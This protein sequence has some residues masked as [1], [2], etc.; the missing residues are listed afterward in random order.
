LTI[1]GILT[2][3][4]PCI[5]RYRTESGKERVCC[6]Y[7]GRHDQADDCIPLQVPELSFVCNLHVR[8]NVYCEELKGALQVKANHFA[9]SYIKNL[10]G[11][12]F[13]MTSLPVATQFSCIYGML[14]DDFDGDGNLD[15]LVKAMT[16]ERSFP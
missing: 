16:M 3:C 11:G 6:P 1:T 8:Q 12:K 5:C 15:V 9:N 13:E 2:W 10:G 14:A 4:L 7:K